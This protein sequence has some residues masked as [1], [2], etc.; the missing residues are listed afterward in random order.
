MA[1]IRLGLYE[2]QS[3]HVPEVCLLCG[4]P[5]TTWIKR[6]FSWRPPDFVVFGDNSRKM[7]VNLPMCAAHRKHWLRRVHFNLVYLAVLILLAGIAVVVAQYQ[8]KDAVLG[9]S[10]FAFVVL[11]IIWGVVNVV[12]DAILVKPTEITERSISFKGVSESFVDA[13]NEARLKMPGK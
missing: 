11:L 8:P 7:T 3:G 12:F 10:C 9:L 13:V 1:E 6:K 4:A 5:A 2:M